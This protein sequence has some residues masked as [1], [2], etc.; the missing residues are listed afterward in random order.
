[1]TRRRRNQIRPLFTIPT[2]TRQVY[3]LKASLM[4]TANE[5]YEAGIRR[6]QESGDRSRN[7]RSQMKAA[8]SVMIDQMSGY[9]HGTANPEDV[10]AGLT[11]Q[12]IHDIFQD[13]ILSIDF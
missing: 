8:C 1:M 11:L 6:R 13:S 10:S 2:T 4:D 9:E 12:M 5:T 3:P 7:G